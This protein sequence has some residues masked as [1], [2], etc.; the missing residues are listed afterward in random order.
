VTPTSF[1]R[2][3]RPNIAEGSGRFAPADKA[4]FYLIARGSAMECLAALSLMSA[5]SLVTPE[6]YRRCRSL[7]M[8][9]VAMLTRLAASMQ[10]RSASR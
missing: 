5:R 9:V 2:L 3:D 6:L 8:R 1:P 10:A 4:H 7:L